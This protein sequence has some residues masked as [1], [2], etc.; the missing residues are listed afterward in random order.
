MAALMACFSPLFILLAFYLFYISV[1]KRLPRIHASISQG[2]MLLRAWGHSCMWISVSIAKYSYQAFVCIDIE[3]QQFL[4][5]VTNIV[6]SKDDLVY[7]WIVFAAVLGIVFVIAF[8]AWMTI[9]ILTETKHSQQV[10]EIQ[11]LTRGGVS[12]RPESDSGRR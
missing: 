6:C 1:G 4:V 7:P 2:S 3:G 12:F 11:R 9:T 10:D 5:A 8:I